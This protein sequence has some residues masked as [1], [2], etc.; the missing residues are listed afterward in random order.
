MLKPKWLSMRMHYANASGWL[1][2]RARY[3]LLVHAREGEE[4]VVDRE[5]DLANN[6]KVVAEEIVVSTNAATRGVLNG[7]HGMFRDSQLNGS[8]CDL[9]LV[10]GDHLAVWVLDRSCRLTICAR[11][12][13]VGHAEPCSVLWC[14]Q[15]IPI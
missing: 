15:Q 10:A 2:M 9:E 11:H 13:L 3:L 6:V 12:T 1:I 4:V 14:R 5:L 8:E 7:K